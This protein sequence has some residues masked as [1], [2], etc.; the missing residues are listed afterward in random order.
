V[1]PF[2]EYVD[3]HAP[4]YIADLQRLLR[5]PS[6]SAQGVGVAETAAMVQDFFVAAGGRAR[7]VTT[8][9]ARPVVYAEFEGGPG[10][11]LAFYNHYDVQPADPLDLWHS[12]PFSAEIRKGRIWARGAADNKGNLMARIAAIRAYRD[13]YGALP[14]PVKFIVEGE[15]EVGS[16][17]LADFADGH[18]DLVQA[19]GCVWEGGFKDNTG[20]PIIYCGVKGICYVEIRVSGARSDLHSMWG[21]IAPNPVWRL[22]WALSRLKTPDERVQIPGF[23]DPV[24]QPTPRDLDMLDDIPFDAAE[25]A[26]DLGFSRFVL[27]LE[28]RRL[29]EQH[30]FQPTCTICGVGGGY[31]G[32]GVKTVLPNAAWAKVDF[33]LVPDQDP[34]DVFR[35]FRTFLTNE[36]CGD[37]EVTLLAA[38]HPARTPVDDRLV[39]ASVNVARTLYGSEPILYPLV[40]GSGPMYALCQKW[41]IPSC[42][43]PGVSH[44]GANIHAPNENIFIDDYVQTIK[45]IGLLMAEYGRKT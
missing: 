37:F 26:A 22:T 33:R 16:P 31:G 15:E 4:Q 12:D 19:S 28:G 45:G 42:A 8:P 5:Q 30:F 1:K 34:D 32:L 44:P 9:G 21:S 3:A 41:G 36:G 20:R 29:L 6:I 7:L 43:A 38:E 27:G 35:K 17:H 18:Q 25:R 40:P 24:R 2:F 14:L 39:Q 10:P 23:Y 11:M 13:V